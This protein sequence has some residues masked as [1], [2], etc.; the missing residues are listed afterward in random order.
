MTKKWDVFISHAG[1]DKESVARPLAKALASA[2]VRVWLDDQELTIGDSLSSK[3]DEGLS[4]SQFGVVVLS[5]AFFAKHWPQKE[6]SGL[7]ARE[8]AGQKVILPVWHNVDKAIVTE[9][10]PVLGDALASSTDRGIDNI[11]SD[12]LAVV[13]AASSDSPSAKYPTLKR[14]LI[15]ILESNPTKAKITNFLKFHSSRLRYDHFIVK[16]Y[17]FCRKRFDGYSTYVGHGCSLTLYL[18]TEVYGDPFD[19]LEAVD[20]APKL[21]RFLQ[22]TISEIKSVQRLYDSNTELQSAL[23][24]ELILSEKASYIVDFITRSPDWKKYFKPEVWFNV[25]AGRRASI[26][27]SAIRHSLWSKFRESDSNIQI[28]TYDYLVE[29]LD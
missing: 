16:D 25:F 8:D 14:R 2:G 29:N 22:D 7:R 21:S 10:S 13:F 3:I 28:H 12:I 20:E 6:L 23:Q 19:S 18:F 9:F 11:V 15:K 1:E 4:K 26:D 5:P 17:E 24:D 27:A